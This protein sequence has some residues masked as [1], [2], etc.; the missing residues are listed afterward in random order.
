MKIAVLVSGG[1]TNLQAILVATAKALSKGG[2]ESNSFYESGHTTAESMIY[3][4][5]YA[6]SSFTIKNWKKLTGAEKWSSPK[7]VVDNQTQSAGS[8]AFGVNKGRRFIGFKDKA[9]EKAK[10]KGIEIIK[11]QFFD[12]DDLMQGSAMAI[13]SMIAG[14]NDIDYYYENVSDLGIFKIL[15]NLEKIGNF[16]VDYDYA[17]AVGQVALDTTKNVAKVARSTFGFNLDP[18]D[19]KDKK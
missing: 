5:I 18:K 1:G 17:D 15:N 9:V 8:T 13:Y 2:K 19:E 14:Y 12:A 6:A 11:N 3:G 10:E 7:V 16:V 4:G